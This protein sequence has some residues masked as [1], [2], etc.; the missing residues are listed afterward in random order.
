MVKSHGGNDFVQ[1]YE[2]ATNPMKKHKELAGSE[3]YSRGAG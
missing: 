1:R 2:H 3:F